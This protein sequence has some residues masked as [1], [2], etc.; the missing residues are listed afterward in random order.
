MGTGGYR[1]LTSELA[2][3]IA[4]GANERI[5]KRPAWS[6]GCGRCSTRELLGCMLAAAGWMQRKTQSILYARNPGASSEHKQHKRRHAPFG[7]PAAV[8]I[9]YTTGFAQLHCQILIAHIHFDTAPSIKFSRDITSAFG[10]C[11]AI[12]QCENHSS[13]LYVHCTSDAKHTRYV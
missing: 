9:A 8:Q 13:T 11:A 7:S 3:C 2:A 5:Q 6:T 1:S 4:A 12:V 10:H